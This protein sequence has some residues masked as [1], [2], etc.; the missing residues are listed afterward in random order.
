MKTLLIL[1]LLTS[2]GKSSDDDSPAQKQSNTDNNPVLSTSY[3]VEKPSQLKQCEEMT[4]G[5]LAY[6][7]ET[8]QFMACLE[9]GWTAVEIK[10]KDGKDGSNG[11]SGTNGAMVSGNQWYDPITMKM[12]V[13]TTI[14][15][16]TVG[17][18]NS[19]SA[20]TGSYRMPTP[21]EISLA[22]THGMKACAQALVSPPT[23]II[24]SDGQTYNVSNGAL[25][26]T[27]SGSQFC[28]AN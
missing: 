16:S 18:S 15:T 7:K 28:I 13:M 2:C 24:A 27:G 26:N 5:Y 21:A 9:S 10:G 25:N 3:Y 23:L 19:Q 8:Q 20:C 1:A 6:V 14:V 17:W 4:R 12:W 22:L 11:T